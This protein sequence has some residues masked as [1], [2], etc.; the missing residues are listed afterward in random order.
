MKPFFVLAAMLC[1]IIR[2]TAV[3]SHSAAVNVSSICVNGLTWHQNKYPP[4]VPGLQ[5]NGQ[6]H[7]YQDAFDLCQQ[8]GM[9][10]P[11]KSEATA[12]LGALSGSVLTQWFPLEGNG[13]GAATCAPTQIGLN[14]VWWLDD[15]A[16]IFCDQQNGCY[17]TPK[18]EMGSE[19]FYS[20]R[21][22][23]SSGCTSSGYENGGFFVMNRFEQTKDCNISANK[24]TGGTLVTHPLGCSA[25]SNGNGSQLYYCSSSSSE[26]VL[27]WLLFSTSSD[28]SGMPSRFDTW[29][30]GVCERD[31]PLSPSTE[32]LMSCYIP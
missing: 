3:T 14:G 2:S 16:A 10:L 21:C 4:S 19:Y 23:T 28:C 6:W 26:W 7:Q 5:C 27:H 30:Q 17:V 8:A 29:K 9:R 13:G 22:V 25:V 11:S 24:S 12:L 18:E 31:G 20:V 15:Q 1:L 32:M